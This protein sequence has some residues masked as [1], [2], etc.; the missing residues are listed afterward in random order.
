MLIPNNAIVRS[1]ERQF[2]ITV[3]DRKAQFVDIKE[4]FKAKDSTEVFGALAG[5]DQILLHFLQLL[6]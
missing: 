2:V 6:F 4:G 3:K 1:A 5:G